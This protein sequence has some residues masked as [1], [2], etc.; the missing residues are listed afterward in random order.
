MRRNTAGAAR[1]QVTQMHV[2]RLPL[3]NPQM[4][5]MF[6]KDPGARGQFHNPL[7]MSSVCVFARRIAYEMYRAA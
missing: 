3:A 4:L 5:E 7:C 6:G 2:L 1:V